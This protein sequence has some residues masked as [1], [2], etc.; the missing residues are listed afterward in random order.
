[1]ANCIAVTA[2]AFVG[3]LPCRAIEVGLIFIACGAAGL[4]VATRIRRF[5][6]TGRIRVAVFLIAA[7]SAVILIAHS[8]VWPATSRGD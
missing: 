7:A 4:A 8:L 6:D 5:L 2:L 1:V 3:Y